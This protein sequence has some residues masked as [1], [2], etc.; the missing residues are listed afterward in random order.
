MTLVAFLGCFE[1]SFIIETT[2]IVQGLPIV[3]SV[4]YNADWSPSAND[5]HLTAVSV[6]H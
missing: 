6:G 2:K 1:R 5:T 3:A 4:T